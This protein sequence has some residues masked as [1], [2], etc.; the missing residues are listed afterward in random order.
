MCFF[1]DLYQPI[2]YIL[3]A[4]KPI[5]SPDFIKNNFPT[6]QNMTY[7]NNAAMGIPPQRAISAMQKYLESRVEA[8]GNFEK[9]LEAFKKIRSNL[10]L[11]LGGSTESY[12][13]SP[14]TSH[15]LNTFAHG[16]DYP[17]G[18]NIVICDLEFPANYVPWQNAARVYG[19]ELRVV[20]SKNGSVTHED[21]AEKIDENTRVVAVSLVQFGS[22]YRTDVRR[23]ARIA[24]EHG[25]YLVTDIIQAAGWQDIDLEKW[26][27]DFAAAQ[28]AKWLIGPI[29]AGFVY[30]KKDIIADVN[31]RFLGWWSVEKMHEFEYAERIANPDATKF[32]I[33]SPAMIAYVGFKESIKLLLEI[34]AGEREKAALDTGDYL[35][36]RLSEIN[37]EFYEFPEENLSPIVSC[38]PDNIEE[39]H[40][41][42]QKNNIHCSV[43]NGRLRVSP[44]FYNTQEDV[45]RLIE[46]MRRIDV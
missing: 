2:V 36:T 34:P 26:D 30:V 32:E 1:S 11:L 31:P 43:R 45:D 10:A 35:R 41:E 14:S 40:E 16:I 39:L 42:L 27:V 19:S 25:A 8:K 24:H 7:L 12:G 28:A 22:G 20:R 37:V 21:M 38:Q 23:L 18:S 17:A 5:L 13:F 4:M 3:G 9:T 15:G 29:G 46:K 6:L 44:H 33:G